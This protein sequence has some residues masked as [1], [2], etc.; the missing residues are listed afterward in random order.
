M[1]WSV[2]YCFFIYSGGRADLYC[3]G[4]FAGAFTLRGRIDDPH[5]GHEVTH[6]WIID[7]LRLET[8]FV[9]RFQRKPGGQQIFKAK[10]R[11]PGL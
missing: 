1:P 7:M 8:L 6:H 10:F 4:P 11:P 9:D 2:A 5:L 3:H